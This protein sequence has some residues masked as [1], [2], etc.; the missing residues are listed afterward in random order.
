MTTLFDI[1]DMLETLC[2]L[3]EI[4]HAAV[5]VPT[6]SCALEEGSDCLSETERAF[7][8]GLGGPKRRTEFV[9]GRI[10][11]RRCLEQMPVF[12]GRPLSSVT[13]NRK[14]SGAPAVS[15]FPE[16]HL[17]ISHA[18][19][20]AVAAAASF[21]VGIDLEADEPRPEC[22]LKYFF[23]I[24]EQRLI[25]TALPAHRSGI[26]NRLWTRKEA[27]VKAVGTGGLNG[28]KALDCT[29]DAVMVSM[30][31]LD[32]RS[33]MTGGYIASVAYAKEISNG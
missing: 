16:V 24:K 8:G 18:G 6:D 15:G 1:R 30:Q 2:G 17:S 31:P 3:K 7:C 27:A 25:A 19:E 32:L 26:A 13:I 14:A 21:P 9:A 12:S 20:Y 10:A 23:S 28:F 29:D 33:A 22:L 4:F 11:A 5:A